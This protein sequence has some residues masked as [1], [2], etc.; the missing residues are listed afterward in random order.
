MKLKT[1]VTSVDIKGKA[2]VAE[3]PG[4]RRHNVTWDYL[5]IATGSKVW[6]PKFGPCCRPMHLCARRCVCQHRSAKR[7]L[8]EPGL[9]SEAAQRPLTCSGAHRLRTAAAA[10]L[11]PWPVCCREGTE[12]LLAGQL[13]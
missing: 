8:G 7:V 12:A 13:P 4:P 10:W 3:A 2:L 5:I 9:S 1:R 11:Q 6:R